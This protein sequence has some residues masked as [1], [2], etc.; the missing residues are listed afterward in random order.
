[1][2]YWSFNI[3]SSPFLFLLFLFQLFFFCRIMWLL[4]QKEKNAGK[5][6]ATCDPIAAWSSL[7]CCLSGIYFSWHS[8]PSDTHTLFLLNRSEWVVAYSTGVAYKYISCP[9]TATLLT[10]LHAQCSVLG[11]FVLVHSSWFGFLDFCGG[12]PVVPVCPCPQRQWWACLFLHL[13]PFN[14]SLVNLQSCVSF[15]CIADWFSYACAYILF[16]YW[17][18]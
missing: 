12:G 15:R 5:D 14:L 2:L 3:F 16:R 1:M 8:F 4:V 11:S 10:E 9:L 18:L 7:C 6:I 17:L 13:F